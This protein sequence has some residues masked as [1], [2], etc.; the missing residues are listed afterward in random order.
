MA[1]WSALLCAVAPLALAAGCAGA[2]STDGRAATPYG[3][4]VQRAAAYCRKKGMSMRMDQAPT[5][6]RRG[7]AAP[8]LHFRCVKRG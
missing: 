7:Q 2:G 3:E 6:T 5:P 1:R 8:A 4:A